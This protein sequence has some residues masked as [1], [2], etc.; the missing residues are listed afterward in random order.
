MAAEVKERQE[1]L[2]KEITE[3]QNNTAILASQIWKASKIA[4]Q[5]NEYCKLKGINQTSDLRE[6]PDDFPEDIK[7]QGVRVAKSVEQAK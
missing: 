7:K 1:I 2:E 6:V 3:K 5:D 4:T